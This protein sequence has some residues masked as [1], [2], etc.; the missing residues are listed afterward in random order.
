VSPKVT[1]IAGPNG[2]GK[3]SFAREYLSVEQRGTPFINADEIARQMINLSGATRDRAAA[4]ALLQSSASYVERRETF[5]VETTLASRTYA[6]RIRQWQ[7]SGYVVILIYLRLPSVDVSIERVRQRVL[8]G[9]HDIP[10][11]IIRRRFDKSLEYLETIYKLLVDEWYVW[12]SLNGTFEL[13]QAWD[14]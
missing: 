13:Q 5:M 14:Q 6:S 2:A 11:I 8:A 1:L 3:T 7:V 9:G 12:N 10:E 4:K